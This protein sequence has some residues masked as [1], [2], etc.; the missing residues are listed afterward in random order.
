MDK[1]ALRQRIDIVD[2]IARTVDLKKDGTRFKG[3]C[4]F[5]PDKKSLRLVVYPQS[6]TWKCFGCSKSGDAFQWVMET[7]NLDFLEALTRLQQQYGH[8]ATESSATNTNTWNI[9][10][11]DGNLVAQHLRYDHPGGSKTYSWKRD[12]QDGLGGLKVAELPLYGIKHLFDMETAAVNSIIIT[13]G[14]G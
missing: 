6:R 5:H 4:P 1:D 3:L 7:E 8:T 12:G 9:T 10:D 2:L 13:E 11:V 14:Q